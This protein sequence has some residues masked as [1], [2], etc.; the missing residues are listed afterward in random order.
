[1]GRNQYGA[2]KPIIAS[3]TMMEK[4]MN[5]NQTYTSTHVLTCISKMNATC[6]SIMNANNDMVQIY[7]KI[8][9]WHES[10]CNVII[11]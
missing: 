8:L 2:T 1:M 3:I 11:T 9:S 4:I 5:R 10:I 6:N 7:M